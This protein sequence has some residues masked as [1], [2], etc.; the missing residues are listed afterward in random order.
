MPIVCSLGPSGYPAL[1]TF[2]LHILD[3]TRLFSSGKRMFLVLFAAVTFEL[4]EEA[5]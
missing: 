5:I 3:K 1:Q 2:L 4:L